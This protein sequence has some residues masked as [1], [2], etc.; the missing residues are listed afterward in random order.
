VRGENV[1]V[2]DA[3]VAQTLRG[4]PELRRVHESV[5]VRHQASGLR[6]GVDLVAFGQVE[7]VGEATDRTTTDVEDAMVRVIVLAGLRI[8]ELELELGELDPAHRTLCHVVQH[9]HRFSVRDTAGPLPVLELVED[10]AERGLVPGHRDRLADPQVHRGDVCPLLVR[11]SQG[12][13]GAGVDRGD[14]RVVGE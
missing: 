13:G 8:L 6:V 4:L 12:A 7:V 9:A 5:G 14:M 11:V 1:A 3:V 10:V 2:L